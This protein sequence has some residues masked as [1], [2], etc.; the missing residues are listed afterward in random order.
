M[1]QGFGNISIFAVD[2]DN[3]TEDAQNQE[4]P[5][6]SPLSVQINS[7]ASKPF[8]F[9][10]NS[11]SPTNNVPFSHLRSIGR[12]QPN[13]IPP[14]SPAPNITLADR[15]QNPQRNLANTYTHHLRGL[16]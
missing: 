1:A 10:L 2:S 13:A 16:D 9:G 12:N 4:S 15:K 6:V 8:G 11:V 7:A 5:L 14:L 3:E